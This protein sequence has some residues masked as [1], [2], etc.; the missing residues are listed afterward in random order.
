VIDSAVIL[1]TSTP[2]HE[3]SISGK[4]PHAMLPALGKPMVVRVMEQLYRAGIRRYIVIVGMDEGEVASYLNRQ[5][6]PDA[7]VE[8]KLKS[9]DETLTLLLSR[10]A[11]ELNTT[12]MIASYNSFTYERFVESMFKHHDE[13]P[14]HLILAGAQ[15]SLSPT[16]QHYYACM[17]GQLIDSVQSQKPESG[18]FYTLTHHAIVGEHFLAYLKNM[19]D[20]EVMRSPKNFFEL[21]AHYAT[22]QESKLTLAETSWILQVES[23]KNLLTLNKRLLEDS[24]DSHIL[25]E[26]P[27]T[28][29][30]IPPV[31]IDPQ[32]SVGQGAVIGPHVYVE[33]GASIGY[34]AKIKNAVI[35]ERSNVP[36]NADIDGAIVTKNNTIDV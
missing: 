13:Y 21:T 1:A 24:N 25:S 7:R 8:F 12:H 33:R 17:E 29:R 14:Q 28:V 2:G 19:D 9:S 23:D 5:W 30:V 36:A 35:L 10:I 18:D 11:R 20:R 15:F 4:R 6:M 16:A 32:V 26:L 27:Y 31:R 3:S 34:E 22:T